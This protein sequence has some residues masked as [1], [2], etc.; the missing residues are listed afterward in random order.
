M[1]MTVR[2]SGPFEVKLAPQ[3]QPED[4]LGLGRMTLDKQFHGALEAVS[5]GQMLSAMT[6]T[7][8]SAGYVALE[9]VSGSLDG[10]KGSFVLQHSGTMNRGEP[11]LTISVVP[12]SGTGELAGLSGSMRIRIE[13]GGKHFYDFDYQLA[14]DP[15]VGVWELDP[16]TLQYESGRPGR[17]ATYSI[18]RSPTGLLFTLDGEDADGKPLQFQYSGPTDGKPYPLGQG[19]GDLMLVLS[20]EGDRVI[21]SLLRRGDATLD[22]WRR[23]VSEDGLTMTITQF[24]A[25]PAGGEFRN[26]SLYRRVRKQ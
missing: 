17:S 6:A 10:R 18:E 16:A 8:G 19:G 2:V 1:S 5:R 14:A 12:D 3:S 23:E 9:I 24:V 22:R 4:Q 7:K 21:D 20:R 11:S 25:N 15:F 26:V 13:T